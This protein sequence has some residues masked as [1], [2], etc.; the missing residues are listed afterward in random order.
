MI[1]LVGEQPIPNLLPIRYDKPAQVVLACTESTTEVSRRLEK[2][3]RGG[4]QVHLLLVS[5]F[6]IPATRTELEN[7]IIHRGWNPSQMV[8]NLTGGTKAMAFAAYSLAEERHCRFLY[9]ESEEVESRIYRYRFDQGGTA[10]LEGEEIIPGVIS[11]DDYLKVHLG[12]YY[13]RGFS[14]TEGGKFEEII[15]GVLQPVVDEIAP[16]IQHGGALDI[17][18]VL[19]CA[20]QVGIAEVKTG[21][22]SRTSEGIKQLNTGG[23][24][25]FL[26]I[27]TKKLLIVDTAWDPTLSGLKDLAEA[28][29]IKVI[30]L[31]GYGQTKD[32]SDQD[33]ERLVREVRETLGG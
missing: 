1:A 15:Y 17:D 6:G 26:G 29:E 7:F 21:R 30:E 8:F 25:E 28:S 22:I 13:T 5:P 3:L 33:R 16:G 4:P 31:P 9:L 10:L 11:L 24:R 20:N 27:Y 12:R 23:R 19:R 2:V 18:L 32:L 14:P